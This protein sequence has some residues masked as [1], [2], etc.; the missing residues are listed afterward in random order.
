MEEEMKASASASTRWVPVK[1]PDDA[2]LLEA[3]AVARAGGESSGDVSATVRARV[4]RVHVR[5]GDVV[6]KGAAIVDV[7]AP[8]W[9]EAAA[10]Y[11][12]AAAQ[13]KVNSERAEA[14]GALK[15]EGLVSGQQLFEQQSN[16][17]RLRAEMEKA[18]ATLRVAGIS[19]SG[20]A[21]ILK[22]G[23]V[24]LEA[25]LSGVVTEVNARLGEFREAGVKPFAKITGTAPAHI[26]ARTADKWPPGASVQ[27]SASDGRVFELK[28]TPLSS[29][30]SVDDGTSIHWYELMDAQKLLPDGLWGVIR[31]KGPQGVWQVPVGAVEIKADA[32][33]LMR[34]RGGE[35]QEV[36]VQVV[37][38]SGASAWVR[39][40]ENDALKQ[41]DD[42]AENIARFREANAP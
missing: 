13:L 36:S 31:L 9:V 18:M 8:E 6:K 15:G 38:A 30:L 21:T 27:F 34:R 10:S 29:V 16:V 33:L 28:P 7:A 26:E 39:P 20:A 1:A 22:T 2:S 41:G 17:A 25:P 5:P 32:G 12:Y 14:L 4:V 42:V 37:V 23:E 24:T 40:V 11:R 35:T 3:P 19:P